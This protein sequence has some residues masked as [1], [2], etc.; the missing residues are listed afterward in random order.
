[1]KENQP[2]TKFSFQSKI[3]M[4]FREALEELYKTW[5][6]QSTKS[7][8]NPIS[9]LDNFEDNVNQFW[10]YHEDLKKRME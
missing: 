6:L 2:P 3:F 4:I 9:M 10:D 8:R 5:E 7:E 1:M